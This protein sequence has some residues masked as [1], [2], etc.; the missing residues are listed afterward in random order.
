M[1]RSFPYCRFLNLSISPNVDVCAVIPPL[2]SSHCYISSL[3]FWFWLL[4]KIAKSV[5]SVPIL[6]LG[7][8]NEN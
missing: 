7:F 8:N 5:K 4:S 6:S 3:Q 2:M 1:Y